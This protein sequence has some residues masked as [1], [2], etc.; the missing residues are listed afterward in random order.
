M[1]FICGVVKSL[2]SHFL[3]VRGELSVCGVQ[4]TRTNTPLPSCFVAAVV[5][6]TVVGRVRGHGLVLQL[7]LGLVQRGA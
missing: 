7:Q 4:A 3:F 6:V 5:V 2:D 1:H